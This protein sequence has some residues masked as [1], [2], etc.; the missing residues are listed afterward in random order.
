MIN[1]TSLLS[2][3]LTN[4]LFKFCKSAVQLEIYEFMEQYILL[5]FNENVQSTP[6]SLSTTTKENE[7]HNIKNIIS[8]SK[9]ERE[10][11]SEIIIRQLSKIILPFCKN[12]TQLNNNF[13]DFIISLIIESKEQYKVLLELLFRNITDN[14][15]NEI[16]RIK[17][18]K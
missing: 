1:N 15:Q 8:R 16:K 11:V 17:K 10:L 7:I 3:E 13:I 2:I 12:E 4:F 18:W 9:K 5:G 6:Q 14:K